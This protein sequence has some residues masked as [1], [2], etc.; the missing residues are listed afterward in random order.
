MLYHRHQQPQLQ[1]LQ[2]VAKSD[3]CCFVCLRVNMLDKHKLY[4]GKV[5]RIQFSKVK[6]LLVKRN[7]EWKKAYFTLSNP[8]YLILPFERQRR[9]VKLEVKAKGKQDADDY[10]FSYLSECV[11]LWIIITYSLGL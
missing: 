6:H 1:D 3:F 10:Y 7:G 5:T 9:L 8:I 11:G 2:L 4:H